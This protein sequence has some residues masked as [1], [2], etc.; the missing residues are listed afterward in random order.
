MHCSKAWCK[1]WS[2]RLITPV[3]VRV[4][5]GPTYHR[6]SVKEWIRVMRYLADSRKRWGSNGQGTYS[7]IKVGR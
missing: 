4:W 2:W 1:R 3:S 6:T 7:L 5:L